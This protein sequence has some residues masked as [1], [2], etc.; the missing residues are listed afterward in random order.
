[1]INLLPPKE[2]EALISE[3]NKNVVMVLGNVV[4]ISLVCLAMVLF[5]LRFYIL[6]EASSQSAILENIKN[7]H[8]TPDFLLYNQVAKKY[9]GLLIK[10]DNF[11]K[12]EAYF[13]EAIKI[14]SEIKTVKGIFLTSINMDR[15]KDSSTIRVAISGISDNRDSLLVFKDNIEK[16]SFGNG[17]NGRKIENI[18]FPPDN[19]IKPKNVNFYLAFDIKP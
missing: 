6:G 19:W 2:K 1:M 17:E 15:G 8:Q 16:A 3:K 18:Y 7:E 9:N 12:K 14:I 13:N 10:L 11:Y 5:S 4:M